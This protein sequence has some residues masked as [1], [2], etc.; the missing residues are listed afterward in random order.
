MTTY[1]CIDSIDTQVKVYVLLRT[2]NKQFMVCGLGDDTVEFRRLNDLRV[3]V[4][5][6]KL[7]ANGTICEL[8]DGSFVS[9]SYKDRLKR[10]DIDGTVLQTFDH[11]GVAQVIEL[12]NDII[13]S[14]TADSVK[15]WRVSTGEC[16]QVSTYWWYRAALEKLSDD[17]FLFNS[18]RW[19]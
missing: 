11:S 5:S 2:K 12:K 17:L 13:V 6:F 4:S 15:M 10:W 9:G 3:V 7:P 1:E 8:T 19:Y 18:Y 14:G 16:L